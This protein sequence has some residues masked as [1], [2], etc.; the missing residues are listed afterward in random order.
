MHLLGRL[1]ILH[2][3]VI[4]AVSY[5]EYKDMDEKFFKVLTYENMVLMDLKGMYKKKINEL[6][7]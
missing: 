2:Q 5:D 7:Y 3:A 6:K 4:V 1:D